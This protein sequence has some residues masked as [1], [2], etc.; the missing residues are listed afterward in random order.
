MRR[1]CSS[2]TSSRSG[3]HFAIVRQ[4]PAPSLVRHALTAAT[5]APAAA[6]LP[7]HAY[8]PQDPGTPSPVPTGGSTI[9]STTSPGREPNGA[10]RSTRP[11]GRNDEHGNATEVARL[12]R[13]LKL[14]PVT[15]TSTQAS[16]AGYLF[17]SSYGA[18][19]T[20]HNYLLRVVIHFTLP[21]G[22]RFSEVRTCISRHAGLGL[23][24]DMPGLHEPPGR[25]VTAAEAALVDLDPDDRVNISYGLSEASSDAWI[26]MLDFADGSRT[27][28]EIVTSQSAGPLSVALADGLQQGLID[29]SRLQYRNARGMTI[30][31]FP[32]RQEALRSGCARK[33]TSSGL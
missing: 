4:T 6:D 30:P 28:F 18:L 24:C 9:R 29:T 25:L 26:V 1:S 16:P 27:G 21:G 32:R 19:Q 22:G 2:S 15:K 31:W 7:S 23:T 12:F 8:T 13:D 10:I 20:A 14:I 33:A 3:R 5:A 17:H 11:R